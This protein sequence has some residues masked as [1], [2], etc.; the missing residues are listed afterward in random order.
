MSCATA[1]NYV[2]NRWK[3][4]SKNKKVMAI[5]LDFL[6]A[7]ETIDRYIPIQKLH[8]SGVSDNESN[9]FKSYLSDRKQITGVNNVKSSE[10][11]NR[12]GVVEF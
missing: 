2:I 10:I 12:Y 9:R 7:F 3:N 1:V 8:N 5:F 6:R 11:T 4:I